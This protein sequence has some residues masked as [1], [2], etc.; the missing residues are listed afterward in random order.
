MCEGSYHSDQKLDAFQTIFGFAIYYEG[1]SQAD[2]SPIVPVDVHTTL[3][4]F[5]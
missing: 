1:I 5:A 4:Q 2:V 3:Y